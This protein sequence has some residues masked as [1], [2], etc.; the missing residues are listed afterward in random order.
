MNGSTRRM[1]VI[2]LFIV[3]GASAVIYRLVNLQ[4]VADEE[5]LSTHEDIFGGVEQLQP[6][7]GQILDRNGGILAATDYQ[8]LISAAPNQI[9]NLRETATMLS[10][11]LVTSTHSL[12]P[13]LDP[14]PLE[15]GRPVLYQV[16]EPR[17][18]EQVA[19]QIEEAIDQGSITG[20]NV[21]PVPVRYYP[22]TEVMSHLLG[23]VDH[24]MNGSSGI[25]GYYDDELSGEPVTVWQ[26]P[27]LFGQWETPRPHH[28]ASVVLSIDRSIQ[29]VA[30]NILRDALVQYQAESGSIIVMDPK[31]FGILAMASYPAFD[32]NRFYDQDADLMV[33][34]VVSERFEPGSIHKVLTMAAAVDSGK[35]NPG[36]T[37]EDLGMVEV[38][39]IPI[40]NWDRAAHGTTDMVTV[41]AKSLNVGAATV[42][43]W[44]GRETFYNYQ[45]AFG[46]DDYTG[47]DVTAEVDGWLKL[48]GD[49]YWSEA[50]LGTNS[51]GQGLAVTPLQELVA[52]TAIANDG[53]IMQPYVVSEIRDGDRVHRRE[54]TVLAQ[55][56]SKQTA[57]TVTW[58]MEEAL[59]RETSATVIP[60]Y[61]LAGKTG[62][63]QIASGGVYHATD[64]ICTFVGF[65]PVDDP[66]II[67]L[68]KIDKPQISTDLRWG[69]TT[70]APTF[71][72]LMKQLVVLLDIPPDDARSLNEF[73][74]AQDGNQ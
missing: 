37:Y 6:V 65:L 39:G 29:I 19:L 73:A 62:T 24:E 44:M 38:G 59:Q 56:I 49:S 27:F 68:V 40:M 13:M 52:I 67:A 7:R 23:W 47:I 34:P 9:V 3:A 55:P 53:K 11:I 20:I 57:D 48:P 36:T 8:Y 72:E 25:E 16:V 14:P 41:L 61:S 5:I 17:V 21:E 42:A 22:E 32:P 26:F 12:L 35:V 30:D 50:E 46:I 71:V 66:Q 74:L 69:S 4:L 31:T 1:V 43:S 10:T 64:V 45:R 33:N 63:A 54:P 60:G 15:S 28:G 70:A 58:M 51:F 18:T 2:I